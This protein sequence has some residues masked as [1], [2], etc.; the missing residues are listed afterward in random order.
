MFYTNLFLLF[1]RLIILHDK[2]DIHIFYILGTELFDLRQLRLR[3]RLTHS[4]TDDSLA[5]RTDK[6]R[7][8]YLAADNIRQEMAGYR[9]TDRR[10]ARAI[11][12][13]DLPCSKS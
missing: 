1:L 6:L 2:P 11:S 7:Q 8:L 4:L 10:R 12:S 5:G 9:E 13:I 3:S